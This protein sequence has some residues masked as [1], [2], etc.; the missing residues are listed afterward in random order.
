MSQVFERTQ[1]PVHFEINMAHALSVQL[2]RDLQLALSKKIIDQT[3][4]SPEAFGDWFSQGRIIF[5]PWIS[6]PSKDNACQ[7]I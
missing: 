6:F 4:H 2:W 7:F 5:R 1:T 3:N